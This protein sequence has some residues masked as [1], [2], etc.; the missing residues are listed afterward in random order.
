MSR[1]GVQGAPPPGKKILPYAFRANTQIGQNFLVDAGVADWTVARAALGENDRVLEIGPGKGILTRRLLASDCRSVTAIEIDRRLEEFLLPLEAAF[2]KFHLFWGDAVVFDYASLEE[3]P[4]QVV[5]NI[6]YHITTPLTW[7]LLEGLGG[8]LERML[9][10]VQL[11]AA[12]RLAAGPGTKQRTALGVTLEAMGGVRV[13][14]RVSSAA[15]HPR[16]RVESAIV[17]IA[18]GQN[19]HLPHDA[20]WRA[21]LKTSFQQRRKTLLN[22]WSAPPL[23]EHPFPIPRE[24]ALALLAACSLKN[25]ARA[26]E[27]TL[28]QWEELHTTLAT[29]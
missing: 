8:A 7:A 27:L 12:E 16:P 20:L 28:T 15:F 1:K 2:S 11:E 10:M 21:L 5:A 19:R 22:N 25:T 13:V 4:T 3:P 14:R 9:L 6:P 29:Q 26:E 23:P 17:E 24:R 18:L